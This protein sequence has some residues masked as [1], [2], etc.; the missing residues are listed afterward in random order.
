[1]AAPP[2]GTPQ[3]GQIVVTAG[4]PPRRVWASGSATARQVAAERARRDAA[5]EGGTARLAAL[6]TL[7]ASM[8]AAAYAR[9]AAA[10]PPD[11]TL[12]EALDTGE[13]ILRALA[14]EHLA[15]VRGAQHALAAV[16]RGGRRA[17]AR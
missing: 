1:V 17:W 6:E 11:T 7:L 9:D 4:F 3:N 2:R 12:D 14:R 5:G 10:T 16:A 15:V 13:T 8:T